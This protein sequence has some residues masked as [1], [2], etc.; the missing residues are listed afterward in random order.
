MTIEGRPISILFALQGAAVIIFKLG[1]LVG[2][3]AMMKLHPG[4]SLSGITESCVRL[5]LWPLALPCVWAVIVFT[6]AARDVAYAE[7]L[8]WFA[9]GGA[10]FVIVAGWGLIAALA[11]LVEIVG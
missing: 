11:P 10:F 5:G 2:R 4:V 7:I 3:N 1:G 6:R 8:A 9:L